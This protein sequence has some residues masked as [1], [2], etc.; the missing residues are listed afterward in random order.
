MD[1]IDRKIL[2]HLQQDATLSTAEIARRVRLSTTPC[3]RR[4]QNLEK[5]GVIRARVALLE[6][7]HLNLGVDVFVAIRTT[8]H[9]VDWLKSFASAVILSVSFP[10]CL[11]NSAARPAPSL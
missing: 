6:R 9:N 2:E 8:Q 11:C 5:T 3:W 1:T 4:I 10:R 7:D